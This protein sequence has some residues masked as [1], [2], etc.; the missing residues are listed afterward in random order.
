MR[1]PLTITFP[2]STVSFR[3]VSASTDLGTQSPVPPTPHCVPY[4][5]TVAHRP[6]PKPIMLHRTINSVLLVCPKTHDLGHSALT[7]GAT[8][9]ELLQRNMSHLGPLCPNS[10]SLGHVPPWHNSSYA[11]PTLPHCTPAVTLSVPGAN[12]TQCPRGHKR[13]TLPLPPPC[14]GGTRLTVRSHRCQLGK[15]NCSNVEQ[16]ASHCLILNA[17][18][19]I[20][21]HT[22]T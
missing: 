13:A 6:Q 4:P 5:T 21:N 14:Q 16:L 9:H 19:E 17:C 2:L 12:A 15:K 8:Q 7:Y 22:T 10:H 18:E 1:P 3:H 20:A 11:G